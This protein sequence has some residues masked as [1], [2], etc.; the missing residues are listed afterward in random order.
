[1]YIFIDTA[2]TV[3]P[4]FSKKMPDM[5]M[6]TQQ[7][8]NLSESQNATAHIA[9]FAASNVTSFCFQAGLYRATVL[10]ETTRFLSFYC[11]ILSV[12]LVS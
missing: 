5:I 2:S 6:I 1:M 11:T 8:G 12:H 4:S 10:T 7:M 3:V 9:A